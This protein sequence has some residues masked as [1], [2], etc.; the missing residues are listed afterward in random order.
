MKPQFQKGR[1]IYDIYKANNHFILIGKK[2][3]TPDKLKHRMPPA[4]GILS[5]GHSLCSGTKRD[6]RNIRVVA[7]DGFK[8]NSQAL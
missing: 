7:R 5:H 8:L 6:F 1:F 2:N 4:I 3:L